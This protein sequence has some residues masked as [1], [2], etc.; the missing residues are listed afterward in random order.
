MVT[1]IESIP[2][3]HGCFA[4]V[5][6]TRIPDQVV[7]GW[8][9][10]EVDNGTTWVLMNACLP[11]AGQSLA[12]RH[13]WFYCGDDFLLSQDEETVV[14]GLFSTGGMLSVTSWI[15]LMSFK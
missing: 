12:I 5:D 4:I 11:A 8:M 3:G 10:T 7:H 13:L 15:L 1:R 6:T 2:S 14:R 9:K